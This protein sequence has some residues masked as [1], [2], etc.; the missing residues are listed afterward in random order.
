MR[1]ETNTWK[2]DEA[3]FGR[4]PGKF[5]AFAVLLAIAV[6]FVLA[7]YNAARAQTSVE[8]VAIVARISVAHPGPIVRATLPLAPGTRWNPLHCPFEVVDGGEHLRAQWEKVA[9]WP[10]GSVRIAELLAFDPTPSASYT[11]ESGARPDARAVPGPW[12]RPW[13]DSPPVVMIDGGPVKTQ[14]SSVSHRWGAVAITRRFFGPHVLGWVTAY[15]GQDV[16]TLELVLHN[17][18][19]GSPD[20]FFDAMTLEAPARAPIAFESAWPNPGLSSTAP[21]SVTLVGARTDGYAHALVQRGAHAWSLVLHDGAHQ[22]EARAMA[23]GA[24]FGVASTWTS[25]DAFACAA[26]RL[27]DLGY[28]AA[29]LASALRAEWSTLSSALASG[30]PIG[31]VGGGVGRLDWQHPF[32]P[33]DGGTTGGGMRHQ[34][35]GVELASTGEPAGLLTMQARLATIMDRHA[36][37][38]LQPNGMPMPLELMLDPQGKPR[39]GWRSS[40]A[41]ARFDGTSDGAWGWV[42]QYG[43]SAGARTPPEL[44]YFKQRIAG[45]GNASAYE[46]IDFQHWDR[47]LEDAEALVQLSNSPLAAWWLRCNAETWRMSMFSAGRLANEFSAAQARPNWGTSWG[48]AHAH[49]M[50]FCSMAYAIGDQAWRARWSLFMGNCGDVLRMAQQPN[51]LWKRDEISKNVP[52]APFGGQYALSK[53]TEEAMLANAA[54]GVARSTGH[55]SVPLVAAVDRW[56]RDGL[57]LYLWGSGSTGSS[58]SDYVSVAPI[59]AA[60]FADASA[61]VRYNADREEVASPLGAAM[62]LRKLAGVAP[63]PEQVAA[64]QRW[65]GGS[66]TPLAWMRAQ[67]PYA[68]KLDDCAPLHAALEILP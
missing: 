1:V 18:E 10:D 7:G 22:A 3:D 63:S 53:G 5:L 21:E 56:T 30:T 46:P 17:G 2:T 40:G 16:V 39:G 9:T 58:P 29:A 66:A 25:V 60:P 59:K 61:V 14:W 48:R 19:P 54:L 36:V 68:L 34:W 43:V 12:A 20:F 31:I 44:V 47:A 15:H 42:A 28:R 57:W 26:L 51:G 55:Q 32:N 38:A 37:L 64:T 62:L 41:D 8:P 45:G 67:T 4:R 23:S 65:C 27:P 24:G 35:H 52:I 49:G 11:V 33:K 13:I 50:R 6:A